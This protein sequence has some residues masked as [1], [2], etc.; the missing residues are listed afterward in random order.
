VDDTEL[1][2]WEV[3]R[4]LRL[5]ETAVLDPHVPVIALSANLTP[6][7]QQRW[8]DVGVNLLLGKPARTEEISRLLATLAEAE[9]HP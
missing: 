1:D 5:P 2:G 6:D 8:R 4:R 7:S 9:A 3:A